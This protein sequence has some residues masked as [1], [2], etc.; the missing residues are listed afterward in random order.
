VRD[1]SRSEQGLAELF[2]YGQRLVA[3][4]RLTPGDDLLSRLCAAEGVSDGEAAAMG[5]FLLFAGPPG[6]GTRLVRRRGHPT[7]WGPG[8]RGGQAGNPTRGRGP[9]PGLPPNPTVPL[10]PHPGSGGEGG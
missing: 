10:H 2:G 1:R 9:T 4:K 8:L 3:R 6:E 7:R 5:M